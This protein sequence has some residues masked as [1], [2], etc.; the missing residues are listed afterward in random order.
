M[1]IVI[2][3]LWHTRSHT[4]RHWIDFPLVISPPFP[5]GQK[6]TRPLNNLGSGSPYLLL[7]TSNYLG[8]SQCHQG[9]VQF[10][11]SSF[12]YDRKIKTQESEGSANSPRGDQRVGAG[13]LEIHG[14]ASRMTAMWALL[15]ARYA[16]ILAVVQWY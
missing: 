4:H 1:C 10:I 3:R 7:V 8:L 14:G 9:K 5:V 16:T 12:K 11:E 13:K 6:G 2:D 15:Q